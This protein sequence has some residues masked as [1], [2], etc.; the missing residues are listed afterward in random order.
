MHEPSIIPSELGANCSLCG[1]PEFFF[2]FFFF[3]GRNDSPNIFTRPYYPP[4]P[5]PA[6]SLGLLGISNELFE[7]QDSYYPR[8]MGFQLTAVKQPTFS[9]CV[10]A[11]RANLSTSCAVNWKG[12]FP[13]VQRSVCIARL[14][15]LCWQ[16]N[17]ARHR[18]RRWI[19]MRWGE[20]LS[21][22]DL[23]GSFFF[24]PA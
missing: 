17:H 14:G 10:P 5:T 18:G 19:G 4:L 13:R 23:L 2:F 24:D 9:C 21:L 12:N 1:E 3:W 20:A 16:R 7:R 22:R 6:S 11:S 15:N 8:R